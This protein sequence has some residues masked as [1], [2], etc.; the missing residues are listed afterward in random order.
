MH[1]D[2]KPL[3][4]ADSIRYGRRAQFFAPVPEWVLCAGLSPQAVA[5]Y[6]VLLAHVNRR[7]EDGR[8][9]PGMA[10]L[11]EM[12]GYRKRQSIAPYLRELEASGAIEIHDVSCFTGRRH[13]YVVHEVPAPGY[14]GFMSV[15]A[16]HDERRRRRSSV[17]PMSAVADVARSAGTDAAMSA[18]TDMNQTKTTRRSDPD[19]LTSSDAYAAGGQRASS[20]TERTR[21]PRPRRR[22]YPHPQMYKWAED[23]DV[24]HYLV[25]AAIK[26]MTKAGLEPHWNAADGIGHT[27]KTKY[28]GRPRKDMLTEVERWVNLA[29]TDDEGCGWLASVPAPQQRAMDPWAQP[30]PI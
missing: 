16:F 20:S 28:A 12:L 14:T 13:E 3:P 26:A 11:A 30:S 4:G 6:A 9:F 21:E 2:T 19:E 18:G 1:D 15:N 23:A 22:V 17:G 27:L 8:S 7:R 25:G 10:A 29:G 5:L 24:I